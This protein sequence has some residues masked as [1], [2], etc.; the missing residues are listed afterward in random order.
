M[1]TKRFVCGNDNTHQFDK[2]SGDGFCP[3]CKFGEG[4]LLDTNLI[5][6]DNPPKPTPNP[7][8]TPDNPPNFPPQNE[9]FSVSNAGVCVLVIGD[10]QFLAHTKT[11]TQILDMGKE[12][13]FIRLNKNKDTYWFTKL[14]L[15][16]NI[17][18]ETYKDVEFL[19]AGTDGIGE[20]ITR[21]I[22]T[23]I[24]HFSW[25]EIRRKIPLINPKTEDDK[26]LCVIE[27]I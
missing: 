23:Q 5:P 1:A 26:T 7:N 3:L 22:E 17:I 19:V 21:F 16:E 9:R 14:K 27:I 18:T 12:R 6:P 13:V 11:G 24:N 15:T 2:N 4:I 20:N 8:P 25:K 10:T